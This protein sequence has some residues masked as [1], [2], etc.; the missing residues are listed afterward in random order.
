MTFKELVEGLNEILNNH[1]EIADREVIHSSECGYSGAGFEYPV[2]IA[3][4][5]LNEGYKDE[6]FAVCIVSD[7]DGYRTNPA[8]KNWKFI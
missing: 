4:P 5:E 3:I 2:S 6:D 7:D 1:P 8:I